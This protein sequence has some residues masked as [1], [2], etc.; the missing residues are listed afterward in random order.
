MRDI[1]TVIDMANEMAGTETTKCPTCGCMFTPKNKLQLYCKR[2]CA[3]SA[4][5]KVERTDIRQCQKCGKDFTPKRRNTPTRPA[6]FCCDI[7]RSSFH[8]ESAE[9]EIAALRDK[10]KALESALAAI[11]APSK[12]R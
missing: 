5:K 2:K 3:P 10:M 9:A 1:L 6:L 7:C 4:Y 11:K 8:R 12:K